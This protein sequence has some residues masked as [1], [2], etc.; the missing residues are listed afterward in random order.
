M[1]FGEEGKGDTL[2]LGRR[3]VDGGEKGREKKQDGPEFT[4]FSQQS[5]KGRQ[6]VGNGGSW[7]EHENHG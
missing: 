2:P 6:P 4:N 1:G 5:R 3:D 7:V